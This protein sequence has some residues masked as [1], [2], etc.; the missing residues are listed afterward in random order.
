M[1]SSL[2]I[3]SYAKEKLDFCVARVKRFPVLS[4]EL[5]RSFLSCQVS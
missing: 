1:K 5:K 3:E 4:G 2:E